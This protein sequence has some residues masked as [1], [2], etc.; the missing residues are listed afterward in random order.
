[1]CFLRHEGAQP[2]WDMLQEVRLR[3][4]PCGQP[5]QL[6]CIGAAQIRVRWHRCSESHAQALPFKDRFIA[7]GLDSSESGFPPSLFEKTYAEAAK[8]GLKTVAHAG[9]H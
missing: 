7:V 1:M 3:F 6:E 4:H 9:E 8:H 2:A 5:A